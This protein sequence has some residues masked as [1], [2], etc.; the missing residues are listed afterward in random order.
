[1]AS[2]EHVLFAV[3]HAKMLH[4]FKFGLVSLVIAR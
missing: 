4:N 3:P 1:M 2:H